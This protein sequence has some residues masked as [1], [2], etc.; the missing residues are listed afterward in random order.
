MC[1]YLHPLQAYALATSVC[2]AHCAQPSSEGGS[3]TPPHLP[4]LLSKTAP[5]LPGLASLPQPEI[6]G[7][8]AAGG[9]A[10]AEAVPG[11]ADSRLLAPTAE[12]RLLA[13]GL[14]SLINA[15]SL[16]HLGETLRALLVTEL[17][18]ATVV[19]SEAHLG[20]LPHL[21]EGANTARR[22][23]L[24]TAS[25]A[26]VHVLLAGAAAVL[27]NLPLLQ[28]VARSVSDARRRRAASRMCSRCGLEP[29]SYGSR[30]LA[31]SLTAIVSH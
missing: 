7:V 12:L 27:G 24:R 15:Q 29:W 5:V 25:G 30:S 3:P 19:A 23:E 10:W 11:Y 13:C 26:A 16:G 21:A 20:A 17:R 1:P 22:L 9:K 6:P 2:R 14:S 28:H 18:A 8:D 4:A 31:L